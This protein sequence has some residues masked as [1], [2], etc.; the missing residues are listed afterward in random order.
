MT[1]QKIDPEQGRDVAMVTWFGD[2][3]P[4]VR[5]LRDR[6]GDEARAKQAIDALKL[7]NIQEMLCYF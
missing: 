2:K 4:E 5:I 3:D 1:G 6:M 7:V